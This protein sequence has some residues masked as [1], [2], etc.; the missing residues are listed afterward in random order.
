MAR[1]QTDTKE[2][3]THRE[4]LK[5]NEAA[6]RGVKSKEWKRKEENGRARTR[7]DLQVRARQR[8]GKSEKGTAG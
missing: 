7:E 3:Q 5:G 1:T 2:T 8:K 4:D 6:G